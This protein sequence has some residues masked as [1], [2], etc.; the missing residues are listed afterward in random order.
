MSSYGNIPLYTASDCFATFPFPEPEP[1]TVIPALEDIG[2]RLYNARAQYML[3]TQQ[4]LTTTYNLLKDPKNQ[5]NAIVALRALHVEMDRAVLAAYGW[6]DIDVP[7]FE[8]PA[9]PAE[10]LN[11]IAFDEEIVDRLF[12]LNAERAAAEGQAFAAAGGKKG[13]KNKGTKGGDNQHD[14]FE[15]ED[16]ST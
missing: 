4:G 6:N 12:V 10:E 16:T 3:D 5:E 15:H 2:E 9:T 1:R 14:M 8:S 11:R 13:R 7:P